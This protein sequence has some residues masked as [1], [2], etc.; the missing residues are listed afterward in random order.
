MQAENLKSG[1]YVWPVRLAPGVGVEQAE[2][3]MTRIGADLRL[4]HPR[5]NENVTVSVIPAQEV[6]VRQ[7]RQ[8]LFVLMA[9]VGLV[10][11]IACLNLANLLLINAF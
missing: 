1:I 4:E 9:A 10:L 8:L 7:V 6:M 2:D 3:E 11:M 5:A